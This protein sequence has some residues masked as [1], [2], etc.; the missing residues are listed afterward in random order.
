[1]HKPDQIAK[2]DQIVE[3]LKT[4]DPLRQ[5]ELKSLVEIVKSVH[6]QIMKE[7]ISPEEARMEILNVIARL[8]FLAA[9]PGSTRGSTPLN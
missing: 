6:E 8:K 9:H 1:M 2:L 3:N 7:L 4:T 5:A